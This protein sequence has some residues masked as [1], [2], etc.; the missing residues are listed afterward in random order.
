VKDR[1]GHVLSELTPAEVSELIQSGIA[2]GGMQAKLESAVWALEGGIGEVLVAPGQEPD[3]CLRLLAGQAAGTRL[4][5]G[6][7][8]GQRA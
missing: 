5:A 2:H 4:T 8:Q 1:S 6:Q 3:I 7:L